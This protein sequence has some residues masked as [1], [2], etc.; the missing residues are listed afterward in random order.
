[1]AWLAYRGNS[2]A[3]RHSIASK[4]A[5]GAQ[6]LT[7]LLD[8]G[9]KLKVV[10]SDNLAN[11]PSDISVFATIAAVVS[12]V[13]DD[14]ARGFPD[15]IPQ[16]EQLRRDAE[17]GSQWPASHSPSLSPEQSVAILRHYERTYMR[18]WVL[19][20]HATSRDNPSG[21]ASNPLP[22]KY[23]KILGSPQFALSSR[24]VQG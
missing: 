23:V 11:F 16:L 20:M 14:V 15:L 1:V 9:M 10:N 6:R 5:I 4:K 17:V 3:Q 8:V 21:K 2:K 24:S 22:D 19:A 12:E 13:V 7:R 18:L